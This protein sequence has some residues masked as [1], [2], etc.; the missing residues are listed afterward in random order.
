MR[1]RFQREEERAW[2]EQMVGGKRRWFTAVFANGLLLAVLLGLP[3]ARGIQRAKDSWA[4]YATAASCML[5]GEPAA[6]PGLGELPAVDAH[7][8]RTVLA[9]WV[10]RDEGWVARCDRAL[11]QV[12]PEPAIFVWPPA[13]EGELR[14]RE[15]VRVLR[16]ELAKLKGY[17][18]ESRVPH[19]PVRALVQL[20]R[21]LEGHAERAGIIDIP[22]QP[23]VT[24]KS[25]SNTLTRPTRIPIY[26]GADAMLTVWGDD[27]ALSVVAVDKT[28]VS[29][30]GAR[31]GEV[32]SVRHVRP[33]LL[34]EFRLVR[35]QPHLLWALAR[36]KCQK[37]SGGCEGKAM[38]ISS[39]AMPL[40]VLTMPRWLAGHPSGRLDR[41]VLP[42]QTDEVAWLVSAESSR[43][44]SE[45]RAFALAEPIGGIADSELPPLRWTFA[46]SADGTSLGLF[47][48][49]GT[50]YELVARESAPLTKFVAHEVAQGTEPKELAL[51]ELTASEV[52][53]AS[54]CGEGARV[55]VVVGT[56]GE[57]AV[58]ELEGHVVHRFASQ[59]LALGREV[60]HEKDPLRD[61]VRALCL[62]DRII[63]FARTL[64]DKLW[65]LTCPHGAEQCTRAL[66]AE[67]V[68]SFTALDTG[69][70]LLA[71]F[72]GSDE[73]AQIR[74]QRLDHTG[75]S[76]GPSEIPSPCWDP[77]GGMCDQP[78][79]HK[80][81][82]RVLLSARDQTD[83][84]ALESPD[85][86]LTWRSVGGYPG[87][88]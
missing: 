4:R 66:L 13:K 65:Q 64:D 51:T 24:F 88:F 78:Q 46:Q 77:R 80:L 49:A 23:A 37:R 31:G 21:E 57:I 19:D 40:I 44:R 55:G 74:V 53:W 82:A 2:T 5:G 54:F 7:F 27:E 62:P 18:G 87:Q 10:R 43:S 50:N 22:P 73:R 3:F 12:A 14:V 36:E 86:G 60:L 68:T 32:R 16:A 39:V 56:S 1:T 42:P 15:A 8:G 69:T 45:L 76:L 81:G 59:E 63:A 67:H 72:A 17:H 28:G 83:L 85:D 26:A 9:A 30:L 38:G 84:I 33:P 6:Q 34:Q 70:A 75:K 79:L 71:A 20:R 52:P 29:Y 35:G 25:A 61:R 47:H 48:L 58:S 11:A 41:S